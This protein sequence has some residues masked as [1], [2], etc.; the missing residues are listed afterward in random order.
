LQRLHQHGTLELGKSPQ[1]EAQLFPALSSE[2]AHQGANFRRSDDFSGYTG[3]PWRRRKAFSNS[4]PDFARV[5]IE[6]PAL[7]W[8]MNTGP[9]GDS[10][11]QYVSP[12][13]TR[14]MTAGS[15]VSGALYLSIDRSARASVRDSFIVFTSSPLPAG[16]PKALCAGR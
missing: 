7:L 1:V 4:A 6:I 3:R 2:V 13:P 14:R 9:T 15:S 11:A 5:T 12:R 10:T 16:T 8:A